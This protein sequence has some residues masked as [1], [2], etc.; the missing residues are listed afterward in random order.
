VYITGWT[1]LLT[2]L[3]AVPTFLA[4]DRAVAWA[5]LLGILVLALLDTALASPV[6]GLGVKSGVPRSV[7]LGERT[8]VTV[9]VANLT[10]GR[11]RGAIRDAWE[12]SAGAGSNR[13]KFDI[14]PLETRRFL[15]ALTPTRRGDRHSGD[16]TVRIEGPLR[17]AG[18]QRSI[19]RRET[20][21]VLPPF[22]SRRHLPSRLAL[23]REIDGRAAVNL[24]GAGSEF[25][26]LREYVIGDDVRTIDWRATA[27]RAEVLVKT[28]RPERDRRVFILL[29]TS[30]LS[31]G[32]VGDAPRLD[33]SIEAALLLSALA[34]HAGDRVQVVAFD[35]KERARA[36]GSTGPRLMPAL[37]EALAIA[38]PN[39]IE[40]DWPG[41]VRL[42]QDRLSQRALV[43]LLTTIDPS[44]LDSGLADAVAALSHRHQVVVASVEDPEV[45]G[46]ASAREDASDLFS[47]AAA[48][49]SRLE[50]SA[51]AMRLRQLGA[52]IVRGLPADLAPALADTY[53]KLK[54]AGRL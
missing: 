49:R 35:R 23:L 37:A 25:D 15:T 17:L 8:A 5:W 3:G 43:V 46:L 12:P 28:F 4:H 39:L 1:V 29:D 50:T 2:A 51:L 44:G 16:L 54:S 31:A 14:G 45:A 38:Q 21:R 34:A 52:E 42:I 22:V 19:P 24:K 30:R 7:R 20:L 6:T 13:H 11:V 36:L 48:E 32:R 47:A 26:S 9:S 10:R 40:P 18:R 53:L 41:A 27:R 33:A